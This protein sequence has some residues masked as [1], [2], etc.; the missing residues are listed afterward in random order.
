MCKRICCISAVVILTI[1]FGSAQADL[2][3]HWQFDEG[4]GSIAYDS[5]GTNHGNIL[6]AAWTNGPEDGALLFDGVNDYVNLSDLAVI[7]TQFTVAAWANHY[8]LGGG[9]DQINLI[10]SQRDDKTGHNHSDISLTSELT[11]DVPY[12]SAGVRSSSGPG[13][14]IWHYKKDYYEWHHYALT[15]DSGYIKLFIDGVEVN[16]TVNVQLGDYVTSVDYV[17]I[18]RTRYSGR[19]TGFFNG[20]IDDVR[21]YDHALD[22]DEVMALVPEPAT[23]ALLGLG[24]VGLIR[25]N[26]A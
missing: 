9:T 22:A 2:V 10:F 8:G 7:T 15:V 20:V 1:V 13:Q 24:V 21:I 16:S 12:V 6:G 18:G 11:P 5:V 4:N 14:T 19:N 23:I 26:R 17:T 25:R 3:A